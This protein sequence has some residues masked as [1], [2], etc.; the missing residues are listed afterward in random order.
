MMVRATPLCVSGGR[1]REISR[2]L[3]VSPFRR[4]HLRHHLPYP[5]KLVWCETA[6]LVLFVTVVTAVAENS[7]ENVRWKQIAYACLCSLLARTLL[8][9]TE[10]DGEKDNLLR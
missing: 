9:V 5:I 1:Q 7:P 6:R 4:Y 2:R 3:N 8:G 10:L